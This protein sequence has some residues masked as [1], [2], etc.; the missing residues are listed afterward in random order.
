MTEL[1]LVSFILKTSGLEEDVK[2]LVLFSEVMRL[3]NEVWPVTST[4]DLSLLV[5]NATGFLCL[6][7]FFCCL[8]LP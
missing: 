2:L 4:K 1:W 5:S 8:R 7:M 6:E 3:E